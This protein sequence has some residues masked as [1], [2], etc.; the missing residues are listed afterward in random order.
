MPVAHRRRAGPPRLTR[1]L[2]KPDGT[3]AGA[4]PRE[5]VSHTEIA[6]QGWLILSPR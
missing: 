2:P 4:P 6:P 5:T 1:Q 3:G